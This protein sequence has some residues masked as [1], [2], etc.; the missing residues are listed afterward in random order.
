MKKIWRRYWAFTDLVPS[1]NLNNYVRRQLRMDTS[2]MEASDGG[3]YSPLRRRYDICLSLFAFFM[4]P[5][6]DTPNSIAIYLEYD[7]NYRIYLLLANKCC[8][9]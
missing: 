5:A 6:N 8:T 9:V 7:K 3:S 1:Q 4:S 2:L